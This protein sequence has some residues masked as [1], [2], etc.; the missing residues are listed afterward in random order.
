MQ[1]A[2]ICKKN[3]AV[4]EEAAAQVAEG[5]V[6]GLVY[7]NHS[8]HPKR[9]SRSSD[10]F[11]IIHVVKNTHNKS[12]CGTK[13]LRSATAFSML[14]AYTFMVSDRSSVKQRRCHPQNGYLCT[15]CDTTCKDTQVDLKHRVMVPI[16]APIYPCF[17]RSHDQIDSKIM[18]ASGHG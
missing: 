5:E 16:L 12:D 10:A 4:Q 1:E 9:T 3:T 13:S 14:Y 11:M 6:E 7:L 18:K 15:H 8:C 17:Q 2:N